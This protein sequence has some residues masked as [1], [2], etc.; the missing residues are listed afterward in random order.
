MLV[1]FTVF[2][3]RYKLG[4]KCGGFR[5]RLAYLGSVTL[6]MKDNDGEVNSVGDPPIKKE[7]FNRRGGEKNKSSS[8]E[9]VLLKFCVLMWGEKEGE[10]A[11]TKEQKRWCVTVGTW[12]NRL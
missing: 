6:G 4:F 11:T 5:W 10:H 3:W 12:V 7:S 8:T 1:S 9:G 2:R